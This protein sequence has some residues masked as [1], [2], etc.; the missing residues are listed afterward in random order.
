MSEL[1]EQHC[2]ACRKG[3]PKVTGDEKELLCGKIPDWRLVDAQ[4]EERLK[5]VFKFKNFAQA[6]AF[7]NQVGDL[8]EAE[9]HHPAILLEY[10]KVTVSWWT[11]AI[12]GL[13][14]NDFIMAAKT[15]ALL[16]VPE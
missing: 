8:A 13:H 6:Q 5:K 2:E 16:A 7:A 12:G 11:H 4:S 14:R 3:A 9:N 15:D 10:G 1:A